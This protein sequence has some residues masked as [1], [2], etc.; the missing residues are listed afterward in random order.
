MSYSLLHHRF[1]SSS[2]IT[3][4]GSLFFFLGSAFIYSLIQKHKNFS[5]P[6]L[7]FVAIV[8]FSLTDLAYNPTRLKNLAFFNNAGFNLKIQELKTEGGIK[9]LYNPLFVGI[10]DIFYNNLPICHLSFYLWMVMRIIVLD[11][12]ECPYSHPL[13]I[14]LY[15]LVYIFYLKIVNDGDGSSYQ[16]FLFL[17]YLRR[18]HGLRISYP[19]IIF[20]DS[21]VYSL[22]IRL[23]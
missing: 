14:F 3:L 6:L 1:F 13:N 21:F 5:V 9:Y 19:I 15:L 23:H 22:C 2:A 11:S 16:L 12:Q 8:L 17:H 7:L 18:L 20:T 10:R 4:D